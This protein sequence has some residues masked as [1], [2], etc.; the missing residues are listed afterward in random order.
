MSIEEV[1][2]SLSY[3]GIL[4]LMTSNGFWAFPSSQILYIIAGYFAFQGNLNLISVI[5]IGALGHSLG[6]YILYEIARKK[7]L[8]YSIKFIKFFFQLTDPEKEIKKFQIAFKKKSILFLFVGKLANPSKIFI[9]IPAGISKMNRGIYLFIVYIT[10]II[11]ASIFTLIGYYFGKSYTNFGY[12]GII[13]IILFVG[14][15][16]YFY[17]YMNSDEIIKDLENEKIK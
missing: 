17:K 4:I 11:W 3:F 9:P 10:S 13:M 6:N 2:I 8:N 16:T 7:G 14:I 5:L 1:I 12:I 15:S